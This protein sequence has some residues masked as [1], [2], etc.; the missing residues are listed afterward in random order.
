MLNE[1][2]NIWNDFKNGDYI[3]SYIVI[4]VSCVILVISIFTNVNISVILN[5]ILA[6]LSVLIYSMI[7]ERREYKKLGEKSQI[8]GITQFHPNRAKLPKLDEII[9]AAKKDIALYAVVHNS[10]VHGH[11]GLLKEKAKN[12]CKVK[13]L[14][15]DTKDVEGNRNPNL[16]ALGEIRPDVWG[17]HKAISQIDANTNLL[18][19]WL[20]SLGSPLREMVEIRTYT[21]F[22]V[23]TY[24]FIDRDDIEGFVI[25]EVMLFGIDV[26]NIPHYIVSRKDGGKF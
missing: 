19:N 16:K 5:L 20:E 26:Y 1:I 23:A 21:E 11:L 17:R 4:L 12:G 9:K 13:I 2:R 3:S 14:I 18:R 24:T 7:V 6:V 15:M 22:P 25:V 8:E 10:L